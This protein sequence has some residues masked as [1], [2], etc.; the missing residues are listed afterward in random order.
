[1]H[2]LN[3]LLDADD[4]LFDFPKASA[5]AFSCMC[6]RHDVPYTPEVR[7]LSHRLVCNRIFIIK[8]RPIWQIFEDHIDQ[9]CLIGAFQGRYRDNIC[10]IHQFPVSLNKSK[11]LIFFHHIYLIDDKN[12]SEEHTSEL[13]SH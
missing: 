9:L 2:Y 3:L 10:K 4:T 12:R 13:Q 1:M 6:R 11:Y 8:H 5:R 7:D